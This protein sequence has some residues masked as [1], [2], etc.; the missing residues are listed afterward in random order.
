LLWV[1]ADPGCG[2]SVLAKYLA[3]EVIP[4]MTTRTTSYFFFKED[5]EDQRS[6][7]TAL[8]SIL[9]QIFDQ[10]PASF[11]TEIL[12]TFEDKG[13]ILLTSF[14]DLWD[15]LISITT[16]YKREEIVCIFDALDECEVSGRYQLIEAV[17][18]FYSG[19]T[20][21]PTLKLLL[22]SRPYLDIRRVFYP[23]EC[24][25]PTIHLSGENEEEID[26]I[27]REIDLVVGSR[28]TD[29]GGRLG[30]LQEEQ[31][32]L[33]EELTRVPNRTYLWVHLILDI[34]TNSIIDRIEDI[35]S[36]VKTIP[37]TVTTAYERILSKS[38]DVEQARKLLHIIVAA[39]RPLTLQE[40]A[41][42][43][44]IK[45]HHRSIGELKLGP[46][47]RIRN[48]I[49][50]YCGLFVVVVTSRIYLLH[51]TA[52]DFLVPLL[53]QG[54]PVAPLPGGTLQWKGS[55]HPGESSR[56]LAEICMWR[57]SLS[58]FGLR[59]LQASVQKE[60]YIAERTFL[61]YA[62]QYWAEHFRGGNWNDNDEAMESVTRKAISFC[63]T[64]LPTSLWFEIFQ[65]IAGRDVPRNFTPL[66]VASYFGLSMVVERFSK[67]VFMNVNAEDQDGKT[68][69]HWASQRGHD[70]VVRQLLDGGAD[71]NAEDEDGWTPLHWASITRHDAVVR[72]LLNGSA[73]VN[74]KNKDFSTPLHLA[75]FEIDHES[76]LVVMQQLLEAGADIN[77]E[78][79]EGETPL[80]I[81]VE[82]SVI[83][84]AQRLLDGGSNT[85]AKDENGRTPLHKASENG[86][87]I[88][89]QHLLNAGADANAK[90]KYGWTP[91]HDAAQKG[92]KTVVRQLLD[93]G[94]DV[95]A[96][97]EDGWTPLHE[98]SENGKDIIVQ[99]LLNAGADV[100]AKDKDGWTPL[101]N[102]S[103]NGH[104][105]VV[106]QLLCRH[107]DVTAYE[108]DGWTPLHL[109][110]QKGYKTV[111]RQ[112]L[113][114]D[115]NAEEKEGRMA[116]HLAS[117]NDGEATVQQ[118]LESGANTNTGDD[119]PSRTAKRQWSGDC[120]PDQ[121]KRR[122]H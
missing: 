113:D 50:Q 36:I 19:T 84:T 85:N 89:V 61:G 45:P 48:N 91:L 92:Y 86:K 10:H 62:A 59:G 34:V 13:P 109:A 44:A 63:N 6:S 33:R 53:S 56:I 76:E 107:A 118:L 38:L 18:K 14:R 96:K 97:T 9:H 47:D 104:D 80:L 71:V 46:E 49:R 52:R 69:L 22:T 31:Y 5:F 111:V 73:N 26:K 66:F 7:V 83:A 24:E 32:A 60:Q 114:A 65:A 100:N 82:L 70:A 54:P 112:L 101:H 103:Q 25:L 99:Y 75:S 8:C 68:P 1:S 51:Q 87:D 121:I 41:L 40:M 57:L 106:R 108:Q 95:N 29:I 28:V 64:D 110:A 78:N 74:A 81:A 37:K 15:I 77:A 119:G 4:S 30:L 98:A 93:A 11:S 117:R 21:Y 20:T 12:E 67:E 27:S 43:L 79:L 55:L 90:D 35:P 94:A 122:N 58:D 115:A 16:S 102:A 72:Q 42:A 39:A 17:S 116:F 88:M 23:L 105:A 120:H 2:K 3:D